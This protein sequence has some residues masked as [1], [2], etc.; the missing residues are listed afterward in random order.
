MLFYSLLGEYPAACCDKLNCGNE[1]EGNGTRIEDRIARVDRGFL[2]WGCLFLNHFLQCKVLVLPELSGFYLF[3]QIFKFR[4]IPLLTFNYQFFYFPLKR[5]KIF[6]F[7]IKNKIFIFQEIFP[8]F[9]FLKII[10]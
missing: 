10:F 6:V 4:D 5:F 2:F 1:R 3:W 8:V 9:F 7:L